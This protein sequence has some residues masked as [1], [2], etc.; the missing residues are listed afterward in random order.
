MFL[1]KHI[2]AKPADWQRSTGSLTQGPFAGTTGLKPQ[3]VLLL[4]SL[5]GFFITVLLFVF[6]RGAGIL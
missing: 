1:D 6:G 4:L 5:W 2:F 3:R